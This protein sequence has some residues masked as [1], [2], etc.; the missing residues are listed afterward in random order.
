MGP[1]GFVETSVTTNLCCVTYQKSE[2]LMGKS[3]RQ[4]IV[5]SFVHYVPRPLACCWSTKC[6]SRFDLLTEC[7]ENLS[8]CEVPRFSWR[9][10]WGFRS[11]GILICPSVHKHEF[12]G[13]IVLAFRVLEKKNPWIFLRK[14]LWRN[15]TVLCNKKLRTRRNTMARDNVTSKRR[16]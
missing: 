2:D 8:D 5:G 10:S 11:C 12:R 7:H 1:T 14:C 16:L 6:D 3:C 15:V 4:G 13:Q 9:F